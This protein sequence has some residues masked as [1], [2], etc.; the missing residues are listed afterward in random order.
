MTKAVKGVY[1]TCE[2]QKSEETICLFMERPLLADYKIKGEARTHVIRPEVRKTMCLRI[3]S[4]KNGTHSWKEKW[5]SEDHR[6]EN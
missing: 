6:C 1:T 4:A 5:S 3:S 2:L